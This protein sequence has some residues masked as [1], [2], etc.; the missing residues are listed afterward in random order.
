MLRKVKLLSLAAA[1]ALGVSRIV[2]GSGWRR[3]RLLILC[4]HGVSIEDEH[5]WNPALYLRPEFLRA[6]LELV[7]RAG[8]AVLP[9]DEAVE[10]LYAG[11]LPARSVVLTFDD[12]AYDFYAR[13]WPVLE[14]FGYPATV[15]LTTYYVTRPGPVFDTMSSYLIWKARGRELAWPEMFG[16]KTVLLDEQGSAR[17]LRELKAAAEKERLNGAE[18]G[19]LLACLARRLGI[20][21]SAIL[22]KRLLQLMTADEARMLAEKGLDI[23]LHTH[24][25]GV[26]LKKEIFER[27]IRENREIVEPL[28]GSAARHFC[29]PSGIYRPEFRPWLR[30][31]NV[32]SA[33]TCDPG[34]A[35]ARTDRMLM[36]R[37]VD[38]NTLSEDEFTGWLSGI[39]A[40]VPQRTYADAVGRIL[41]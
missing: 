3:R 6:R 24:R 5:E 35:N 33:T 29:Y 18:K 36:P 21:Y 26:S 39:A 11:T 16:A 1:R 40:L 4:Y 41:E 7:R 28:R 25:H 30:E 22:E 13:A 9:L 31:W 20:D 32:L 34:L 27:E 37:L 23:Q 10:R 8:C 38:T 19:E 14:E 15:Y 12:G 2:I 17:A